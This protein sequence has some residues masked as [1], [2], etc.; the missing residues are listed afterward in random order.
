MDATQG[1]PQAAAEAPAHAA[2]YRGPDRRS[3]PTPRFS[4]YSLWGGRRARHRR[5]GEGT[6]AFVDRYDT[7]VAVVLVW[8]ALMNVGDSFFT[9]THLQSGGIELN[10][11]AAWLLQSGRFGFVFTKCLLISLAL[12]VLCQHKNFHL[13]RIGLWLAAIAY[14]A[15]FAYHIFL[16]FL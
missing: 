12:L 15:L 2:S 3:R 16:F 10:P 4:R 13:A 6:D 1:E 5:S 14:T 11:V 8:V 7:S 9:L